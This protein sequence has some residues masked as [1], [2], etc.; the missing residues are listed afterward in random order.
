MKAMN[1]RKLI[2]VSAVLAVASLTATAVPANAAEI[3]VTSSGIKLGM[4]LPMT[5][6]A[7]LGYNKIP[8]AAKAYFDY[9]NANGGVNGGDNYV[10]DFCATDSPLCL[11][12]VIR[13]VTIMR[14]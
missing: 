14:M 7:S 8:G 9:L 10:A 2:S 5:G 1:R 11:G 3:G 6:A 12:V 4:T 13:S